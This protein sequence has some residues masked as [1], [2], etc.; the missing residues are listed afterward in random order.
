MTRQKNS[1][2]PTVIRTGIGALDDLL[3]VIVNRLNRA[4]SKAGQA[5]AGVKANVYTLS[6]H[7]ESIAESSA[8]ISRIDE[9]VSSLDERI[10]S[11]ELSLGDVD[12][13]VSSILNSRI[14]RS[15][16]GV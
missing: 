12:G 2:I 9:D 1:A 8:A 13:S 6:S 4:E 14:W 7:A 11:A 5:A 10:S 15:W 16:F 3:L